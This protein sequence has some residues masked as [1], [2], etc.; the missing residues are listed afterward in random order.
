MVAFAFLPQ[1]FGTVVEPTNGTLSFYESKL[2]GGTLKPYLH[3]NLLHS[4]A[5][6][7][8]NIFL[9]PIVSLLF[10][11]DGKP[12]IH[13]SLGDGGGIKTS[14][15]HS[16]TLL[17]LHALAPLCSCTHVPLSLCACAPL[18]SC[19]L[20]L[21][22]SCTLVPPCLCALG[23][24]YPCVIASL[25]PRILVASH[26]CYLVPLYPSTLAPSCPCAFALLCPCILVPLS[27]C[28]LA[29]LCPSRPLGP[30]SHYLIFLYT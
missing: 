28:A 9:A 1:D 27:S 16:C 29:L 21:L 17:H 12:Y 8:K 26:P 19:V 22:H 2:I 24:S 25:C 5:V 13:E 6:G 18:C 14:F 7:C 30:T 20:T 4:E 23:P 10:R 11:G 15:L 3:V